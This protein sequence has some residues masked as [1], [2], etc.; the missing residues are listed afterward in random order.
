MRI[1]SVTGGIPSKFVRI[2]HID[3][4]SRPVSD[5]FLAGFAVKAA[6]ETPSSLYGWSVSRSEDGTSA[7]VRLAT[8]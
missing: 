7:T 1:E 6:N 5:D 3:P 4:V 2:T 8:D